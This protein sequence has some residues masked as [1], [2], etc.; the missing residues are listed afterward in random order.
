MQT[1]S[2]GGDNEDGVSRQSFKNIKTLSPSEDH[3][4]NYLA[5]TQMSQSSPLRIEGEH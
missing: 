4:G 2:E 3:R 1:Q 5:S